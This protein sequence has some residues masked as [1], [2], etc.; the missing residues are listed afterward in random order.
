MVLM[1][2]WAT[3]DPHDTM[4]RLLLGAANVLFI[5]N[6]HAIE[7]LPG[8]ISGAS[9]SH[10][11]ALFAQ[12][13]AATTARQAAMQALHPPVCSGAPPWTQRAPRPRPPHA[14][15]AD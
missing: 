11:C 4:V 10:P 13:T 14:P 9:G 5:A 3:H 7:W 8:I 2:C 1:P 12:H 6:C 15:A